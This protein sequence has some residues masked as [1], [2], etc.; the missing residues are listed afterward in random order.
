MRPALA[1][2]KSKGTLDAHTNG[3]RFT[4]AKTG[5]SVEIMYANVKHAFFQVSCTLPSE[6]RAARAPVVA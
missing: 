4:G 1:G 3:L 6:A 5:D 2:R